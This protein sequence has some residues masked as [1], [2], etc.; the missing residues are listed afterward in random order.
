MPKP[1]HAHMEKPIDRNT[2][3]TVKDMT[4][5][6]I[7]YYM[8]AKLIEIGINPKLAVYRWSMETKGTKEV[9]TYSAYWGD[10]KEQLLK[11]EQS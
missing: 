5:R 10:S 2:P 9:W 7:E 8:G 11:Q 1:T 6:Q 4:K 3:D